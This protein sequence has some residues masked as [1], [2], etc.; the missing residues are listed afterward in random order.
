MFVQQNKN[1]KNGGD[2]T[3]DIETLRNSIYDTAKEVVMIKEN[4]S[5]L[6]TFKDKD[7]DQNINKAFEQKDLQR[8]ASN[9]DRRNN[10]RRIL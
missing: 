4:I 3:Q 7:T 2:F 6:F 8:I 10:K 9:I 5:K 1:I